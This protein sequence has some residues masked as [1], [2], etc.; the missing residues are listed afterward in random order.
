MKPLVSLV[1]FLFFVMLCA[2]DDEDTTPLPSFPVNPATG[3]RVDQLPP[4]PELPEWSDNPTT[5]AKK[6]LGKLL[7]T[8][9]RLS[10]SGRVSC[11]A[12]HL[13]S[14]YFQSNNRQDLPDRSYPNLEPRLTRNTPSLYNIVYARE[15][16][17]DGGHCDDI[18]SVLMV[19]FAEPNMNLTPG[20]PSHDNH[21]ID[22]ELAKME[23]HRRVVEVMPGYADYFLEAFDVDITTIDEDELWL[24]GGKA[25][26]VLLRDATSKNAPFD[27]WNT[28]DDEAMDD[29][30]IRGLDVFL[31]KGKCVSCH[32]GPFF[33]DFNY[34][35]LSREELREDGTRSDEGR[36][37]ITGKEED[38]GKFLTPTLRSVAM[39]SPFFHNGSEVSLRKVIAHITGP[40]SKEDPMHSPVLDTLVPLNEEDTEALVA[41]I[42]ALTGEVPATDLFLLPLDE[43]P[44]V[45]TVPVGTIL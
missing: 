32:S 39:T 40:D 28:G 41:F 14:T 20:Y 19:P 5:E 45:D 4:V 18:N 11:S 38:R 1:C 23:F 6:S 9:P 22:V 17:W 10:G 3:L 43:M 2:C 12:C 15:C 21:S 7:F 44:N 26:A 25:I 29:Q 27:R 42:K 8:D 33:T 24:L 16:R 30:Q 31:N 34:Y 13:P 35:N 36:F 37:L